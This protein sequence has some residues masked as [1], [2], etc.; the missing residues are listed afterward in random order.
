[1]LKIIDN[2]ITIR[3]IVILLDTQCNS[4]RNINQKLTF[5]LFQLMFR[6]VEE[7][8]SKSYSKKNLD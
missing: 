1:M 6:F 3:K 8:M 7:L 5:W 2:K 4:D